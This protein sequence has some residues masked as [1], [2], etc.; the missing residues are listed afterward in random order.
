VQSLNSAL[1]LSPLLLALVGPGCAVVAGCRLRIVIAVAFV[2]VGLV[3]VATLISA[4]TGWGDAKE[5]GS[6]DLTN[7]GGLVYL[8]F[9]TLV[10]E[11]AGLVV[12]ALT[13]GVSRF[14]RSRAVDGSA[15]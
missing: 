10:A 9:F 7:T 1:F 11:L 4:L 2:P 6:D 8:V 3:L 12:A 14:V 5:P 13:A 15:P